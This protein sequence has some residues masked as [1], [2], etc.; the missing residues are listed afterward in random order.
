ME[1]YARIFESALYRRTFVVTFQ[2]S[3]VCDG[4][5]CPSWISA[6][7]LADQDAGQNSC[8]F[9]GFRA[10]PVLDVGS[11]AYLR[12]AG[13]VAAKGIINSSLMST[14]HNR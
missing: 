10:G 7:L 4:D 11:G 14:G 9:D 3:I 12:L 5:L 13:A 6:V 8:H 1:N 2:I